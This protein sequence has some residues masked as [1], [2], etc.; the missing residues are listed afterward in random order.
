MGTDQTIRYGSVR[1]STPTGLGLVGAEVW[2]RVA[3]T[4]LV[5]G[6][7]RQGPLRVRPYAMRANESL[8]RS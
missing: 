3:V 8:L 5:I 4:E 2:V 6:P 7:W 1:Y